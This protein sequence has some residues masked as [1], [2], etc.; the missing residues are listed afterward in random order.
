MRAV[1][2][3]NCRPLTAGTEA[4]TMQNGK[5]SGRGR[6]ALIIGGSMGGLMAG[7]L[8]RQSGWAVDIFERTRGDLAG[9]GAGL[10][11][12]QELV[13]ILRRI[14]ARFDPSSGSVH[15]E[16]AWMD[17]HGNIAFKHQRAS[18][19]ST[20]PR[21]YQPLRA[22]TPD[23][24]YHQGRT[25][26]RIEQD[27]ASVTAIFSD[28]SRETGDLLIGA[29]GV[30]ST[31]RTQYSPGVAPRYAHYIAWRGLLEERDAQAASLEAI[32]GRILL[33]FP[34]DELLLTM[35]VPGAEDDMRPGHRRIYFIWY[36]P[37]D[38]ATLA[39]MC[40]DAHGVHHGVSIPPPLI[41]PELIAATRAAAPAS[42]PGPVATIVQRAPNLLLQAI[43]DM[44]CP[45][46]VFGRVALMGDAAFIARPHSAAGV[47]KAALD[48][49]CL[50]D[51]IARHPDD[52]ATA[53]ARYNEQRVAFGQS[54][55]SHARDLGAYL[56]GGHH[57]AGQQTRDPTR[58][59][60]DYGAPHLL[61][62]VDTVAFANAH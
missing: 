2:A 13:D 31:V 44:E 24:I 23:N 21:V 56:E 28:G 6:R 30:G 3:L 40:T 5:P 9:R 34:P 41:R 54:L 7:A 20:W 39:D 4:R 59:I 53:L 43:S 45:N 51:E 12:S 27:S 14:G 50:A 46:M 42:L 49:Q 10:G 61:R 1:F 18:L 19:A 16:Y 29:D 55:V 47:T 60:R 25:L 11:I 36:R 62:D 33:C 32:E 37:A 22:I 57:P 52:I 38:A 8:L 17:H 26:A 15:G 58:I 35:T 48:A